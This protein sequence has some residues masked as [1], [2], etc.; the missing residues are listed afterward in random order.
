MAEFGYEVTDRLGLK[1]QAPYVLTRILTVFMAQTPFDD[2]IH[3]KWE[4]KQDGNN[5]AENQDLVGEVT[6]SQGKDN[7]PEVMM[8]TIDRENPPL[9]VHLAKTE[10]EDLTPINV[11]ELL[12]SQRN[13]DQCVQ[14]ANAVEIPGSLFD[15]DHHGILCLHSPLDGAMQRAIPKGL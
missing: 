1:H 6:N 5:D 2:E 8:C 4:K 3:T 14:W 9:D 15:H 10:A 7:E 13:N 12:H 11:Q